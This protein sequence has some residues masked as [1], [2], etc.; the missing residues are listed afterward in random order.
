MY[1]RQP[2][3]SEFSVGAELCLVVGMGSGLSPATLRRGI[4]SVF[5]IWEGHI[6]NIGPTASCKVVLDGCMNRERKDVEGAEP[7]GT[8][9][10][11]VGHQ[12]TA[13]GWPELLL[14]AVSPEVVLVRA[15]VLSLER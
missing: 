3:P 6:A 5:G 1:K 13:S 14:H 12:D 8:H 7:A 15:E 10:E 4:S 9:L 2:L 11:Y